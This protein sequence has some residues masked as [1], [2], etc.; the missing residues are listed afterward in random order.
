MEFLNREEIKDIIKESVARVTERLVE[1][2]TEMGDGSVEIDNFDNCAD[3]MNYTHPG[4]TI[5]FVQ[6]IKRDK[7]NPGTKSQFNGCTY[8]K[9]FYF[10]SN[11][12]FRAAENEI[13]TLCKSLNA[14]AYIYLNAR[15]KAVIDKYTQV[16]LNKARHNRYNQTKYGGHEMALAAGRSLDLPERPLCFL[17]IDSDDFNIIKKVQE[18][19][20]QA[21]ITPLFA[22][23]SLNNGLHIV[24]PDKDAA[25]KLDLS[26]VNGKGYDRTQRMKMNA[27][28]GLEIDKPCLLYACLKPQGYGR[29]QARFQRMKNGFRR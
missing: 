21:G 16:E 9:E 25:K 20:R 12:E 24:L 23:R 6:I 13:K 1:D 29:Q 15:S 14:R 19:L 8:L 26:I 2:R 17:D 10:K 22:Y 4:D 7:D 18:M 5:Y 28:V 3:I 27:V 11:D